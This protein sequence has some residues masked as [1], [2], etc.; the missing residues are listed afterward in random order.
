MDFQL[1]REAED[2]KRRHIKTTRRRY[3]AEGESSGKRGK[4]Y[5]EKR[6]R[7]RCKVAPGPNKKEGFCKED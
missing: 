1:L 4:G 3:F 6:I 2:K 5:G 7:E